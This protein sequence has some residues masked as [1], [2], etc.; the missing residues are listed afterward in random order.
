MMTESNLLLQWVNILM[1]K[2]QDSLSQRWNFWGA[3]IKVHIPKA[4]RKYSCRDNKVIAKVK[5]RLEFN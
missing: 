5:R 2:D 3:C 4:E 1:W